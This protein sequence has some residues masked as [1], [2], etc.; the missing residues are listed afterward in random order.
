[1][2]K[3][4]ILL[5]MYGII[6][7]IGVFFQTFIGMQNSYII[8]LVLIIL[9][10]FTGIATALK[11]EKF[12]STGLRKFIRKVITYTLSMITVRLLEIILNPIVITTIL[13]NMI[14]AFL[15]ITE[16]LSILENLTLLGVPLPPN[17]LILIIRRL[18][19]PIL[20]TIL[21]NVTSKE[22]QFSDMDYILKCEID[23]LNNEYVKIFF[24]IRYNICKS[25]IKQIMHIDDA[26]ENK[27]ILLYKVESFVELAINNANKNYVEK[28]I[29]ANYIEIFSK[30]DQ[31][32]MFEFLEKLKITCCSEKNIREK[33]KILIDD[34]I[35][36]IYKSISDAREIR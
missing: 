19:I 22:K 3:N 8:L 21:E 29:P 34:I 33:K 16:S 9:D 1:M 12:S 6:S 35:I 23:N 30:N 26:N 13:S 17:I 5:Q 15:A 25:I 36:I 10:T 11:Y 7:V 14:I 20:N 18:N 2:D 31:C 32:T 27:D 24:K 28:N 4:N